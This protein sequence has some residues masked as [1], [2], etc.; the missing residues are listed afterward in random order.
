MDAPEGPNIPCDNY[1]R[2][3]PDTYVIRKSAD[4]DDDDERCYICFEGWTIGDNMVRLRCCKHWLH[5]VCLS[6]SVLDGQCPTCRISLSSFNAEVVLRDAAAVG[7]IEKVKQL[8]EQKIC[9]STRDYYGR[10]PLHLATLHGHDAVIEVLLDNGSDTSLVDY[11]Q[12]TPLHLAASQFSPTIVAVLVQRG[13]D[14]DARD[15]EG[16]T[17]LHLAYQRGIDEITDYLL[18]K[19]ADPE[20][21]NSY[22]C[23]PRMLHPHSSF[24]QFARSSF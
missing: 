15:K 6:Q 9:H 14:L 8:L 20:A 21:R 19:G 12:Q 17:P 22:G 13:A 2:P 7:D 3:V 16:M 24:S 11:K 5:E 1:L 10:T 23:T 18:E 4:A